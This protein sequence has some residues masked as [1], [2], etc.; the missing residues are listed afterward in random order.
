MPQEQW[1]DLYFRHNFADTGLYPTAGSLS[2]SPDIVV[3]GG[4]PFS[5]PNQ[6]IADNNWDHD[7]GSQAFAS[8]PNY[9]YLRGKNLGDKKTEGKLYLYAS[10]ASLLLYPTN[11][12][13]PAKGWS[14][15]PIKTSNGGEYVSVN[16][17]AGGRFVS[18]EAFQWIPGPIYGDHYCTIGRVVTEANPNPIPTVGNLND[19]A[20]YISS[21]PNMAWRNIALQNPS[22]PQWT[23][24]PIEYDQ[25]DIGGDVYVFLKCVNAPD[26]SQV[27]FSSGTPGPVPA[28]AIDWMTV[29][30]QP[31]RDGSPT[32]I[33]PLSTNIPANWHSNIVYT[34]RSNNTQPLPNMQISLEALLP[35]GAKSSWA[36]ELHRFALPLEQI[37]GA[38]IPLERWTVH[39]AFVGPQPALVL[40]SHMMRGAQSARPNLLGA[41]RA[42]LLA[43]SPTTNSIFFVGTTWRTKSTSIAG[44]TASGTDVTLQ[45]GVE[46][47][48]VTETLRIATRTSAGGADADLTTDV[49]LSEPEP[50][51][52]TLFSLLTNGVPVGATV[53]F[54]N[55]DGSIAIETA[56]TRV[57]S[58][59]NF[60]IATLVD[61]PTDYQATIRVSLVLG[62]LA[63]QAGYTMAFSAVLQTGP[64]EG[65]PSPAKLLGKV[66][67]SS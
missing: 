32:F 33:A 34:W 22:S 4:E 51:G 53:Q 6:L 57:T 1:K 25:G 23:S 37:Y 5:D 41:R 16:P 67:V 8:E 30:N 44:S 21:H 17:D 19:F 66:T 59:R 12:V 14:Q 48:A 26:G 2:A 18:G 31:S 15:N 36:A 43:A 55:I 45:R 63:L 13:D 11:P 49:L 3:A 27:K 47:D 39:G 9:L 60:Q 56:P 61:L 29:K 42:G 52:M 40:G 10:P 24:P 7:Y 62:G 46:K 35:T 54:K 65:G 28:F 58:E 20:A 64:T 50:G 38:S